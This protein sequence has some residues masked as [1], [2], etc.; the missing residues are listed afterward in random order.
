MYVFPKK[1]VYSIIDERYHNSFM[2][3]DEYKMTYIDISQ[4]RDVMQNFWR[5]I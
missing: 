4:K 2:P 3:L 5:D 1:D